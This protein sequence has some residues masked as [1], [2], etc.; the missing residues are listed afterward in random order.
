MVAYALRD[1]PGFFDHVV[2]G[3]RRGDIYH[4]ILW[5]RL[6]TLGGVENAYRGTWPESYAVYGPVVLYAYQV[7]GSIYR[8]AV[9]ARFDVL[10]A[11]TSA[12]LHR[13]MKLTALLWHVGAA[14][15]IYAVVRWGRGPG[16]AAL[17]GALYVANPAPLFAAANWGQPDGAHVL[18]S[19][20]AVGWLGGGRPL[21]GWA[22]LA[23][24]ALAKPQ[25]WVL[26]PLA[27]VA[28]WQRAGARGLAGGAAGG[29]LA[30]AVVL[31]PFLLSGRLGE[32]LALPRVVAAVMPVVSANAHNLWWLVAAAQ[33]ADPM[34]IPSG[35]VLAG[36][37]TL[38]ALGA[39]LV[40]A[41]ALF[42]C[43]LFWSRRA[44]LAE[45]GALTVLGWFVCTTQAHE[46]HLILALALLAVAWPGRPALLALY[47]TL[48]LTAV[49]NMALHD[50]LLLEAFRLSAQDTP[51]KLV[52]AALRSANALVTVGAFVV[53]ATWAARRPAGA[54]A[55]GGAP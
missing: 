43:W 46:N 4:Y 49:L 41:Q 48:S 17:A 8:G 6:V 1:T 28:T 20:L 50:P 27:A 10:L 45:A 16:L 52:R 40:G 11:E 37:L 34:T 7:A 21:A 30:A 38:Q 25:S 53:W 44:G 26:F 23:L 47:A 15:A 42:A 2:D 3:R 22:A 29:G 18:F 32:L 12:W 55:E 36:P 9:D 35:T 13:A 33:L 19:I 54:V 51:A 31:S 24:A 39:L 5:T 14:G